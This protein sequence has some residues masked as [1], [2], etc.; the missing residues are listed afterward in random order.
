VRDYL[1]VRSARPGLWLSAALAATLLTY[2]AVAREES[3]QGWLLIDLVLAYRV[4]R[5]GRVALRIFRFLQAFGTAVYG[6]L[7][8]AALVGRGG[9]TGVNSPWLLAPYAIALWCLFAPAISMHVFGPA[10]A[11]KRLTTSLRQPVVPAH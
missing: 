5:R 9:L 6:L 3:W 11:P 1:A 4:W 10:A 8:G 2:T 7:I